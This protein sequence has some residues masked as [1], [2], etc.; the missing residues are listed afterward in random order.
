MQVYSSG[1]DL[2]M[3]TMCYNLNT[4]KKH[5]T[6]LMEQW[7]LEGIHSS[8]HPLATHGDASNLAGLCAHEKE[9]GRRRREK[10]GERKKEYHHAKS[11]QACGYHDSNDPWA[12]ESVWFDHR[13]CAVRVGK[14]KRGAR[15]G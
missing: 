3:S 2:L 7:I 9:G 5:K 11:H 8:S 4:N 10:G 6:M 15:P 1:L 13:H 12:P 14:G